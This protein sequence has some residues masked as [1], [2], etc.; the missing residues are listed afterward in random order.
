MY[1][2]TY[3]QI[4]GPTNIPK[5]ILDALSSKAINHRGDEYAALMEFNVK[6]LK[7]VFKTKNDILIFPSSGSGGLEASIVNTLSPGD[8]VVAIN[9]GVFSKRYGEIATS[10]GAEITWINQE[11]GSALNPNRLKDVLSKDFKNEIKAI[12][13][14]HN[15]TSTGVTN[16]LHALIRVVRELN[17]PA[18]IFVDAVSS[19]AITDL[20]TDLLDIDIV[21]TG[22]QK[23]LMLPGG[24]S[25]I[26]VSKR[27]WE[28]HNNASMPK[29]YWNFTPMLERM[30]VGQMP[31]TPV[32]S[33]FFALK[34]SLEIIE[35]EGLENIYNRHKQNADAIRNALEELGLK[36][37]VSDNKYSSNAVTAVYLPDDINYE[38]LSKVLEDDF[39]VIIGGGL[40]QLSG[41]IFR[42]GHLGNLHKPE[43]IAI[44]TSIE[45]SLKKLGYNVTLGTAAKAASRVFLN[46]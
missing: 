35:N 15:E 7:K 42:V 33:H 28:A 44:V 9:M 2:E 45:I 17:H 4:P 6:H 11:W 14:T 24:L 3:L 19:L 36:L 23:G 31:Y 46:N 39:N 21:V 41:K 32:I 27:A 20:P 8:K 26:S 16:D 30:K 5:P 18:L 34:A 43:V 29:W 38:D 10:F 22:S 12:L 40:Q 25:L 1:R 37:L 13:L